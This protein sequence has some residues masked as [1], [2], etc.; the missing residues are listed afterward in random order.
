[1]T[2]QRNA[3]AE[4]AMPVPPEAQLMQIVGGCF[5]SQAV[6]V[7]AKLGIADL[8]KA[9]PLPVAE[10]AQKTGTHERALYRLLRCLASLGVFRETGTRVFELTPTAELLASD[11]PGSMRDAAIFMG[12]PWHWS[13][14]SDM[15]YSVTTGKVAWERVHGKEVFPYFQE[16]PEEYE[17]FN[18]AMTSF[19]TNTL[20]AIVEAYDFTGVKKL[21]D[22][23]GGHGMLLTGFL[24]ANPDLKGL[25]FDLPLVIDGAPALLEKEGVADRVELKT[26]DFFESVPRGADAYM[27]KFI[28]HDWDDE[29]AL[30]IL[31]NI[32]QVL[33]S[34][35]RL[36][37]VEMVVPEGN[38]PHFSKIQDLEMLVSPGGVERTPDEYRDLLAGAGFALR[39]IIPTKSPLSIVE[40][41]KS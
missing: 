27:M 35:G 33:P 18:R 7:A 6:Y 24:K 1:M 22:I 19:S 3:A 5:Q 39:R 40:A 4:A 21:A 36:L 37:L 17:V 14:Y 34:D 13:V 9:Q 26:G 11:H 38:E 16:H 30:K 20:P 10:L 2:T 25:L 41:F 15:L 23:A 31:R 8:L 12:E 32:H 28:I 29:R